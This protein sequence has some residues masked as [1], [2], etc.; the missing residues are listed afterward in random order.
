MKHDYQAIWSAAYAA[1]FV[2]QFSRSY[3]FLA[4]NPHLLDGRDI[5]TVSVANHVEAAC[6]VADEAVAQL[7]RWIA[8]GERDEP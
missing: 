1:S 8:D 3:S 7:K 5:F 4:A 2:E 6:T